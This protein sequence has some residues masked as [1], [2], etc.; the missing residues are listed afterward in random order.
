[1]EVTT[2][3]DMTLET[4]LTGGQFSS[5]NDALMVHCQWRLSQSAHEQTFNI[6]LTLMHYLILFQSTPFNTQ[7]GSRQKYRI[8]VKYFNWI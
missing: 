6:L 7:T 4:K 3:T 8:V 2:R 1:M 5:V